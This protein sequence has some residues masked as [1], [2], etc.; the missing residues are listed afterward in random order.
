M[1]LP[2]YSVRFPASAASVKE[3]DWGVASYG[4][5]ALWSQTQG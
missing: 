1:H 3:V 5:P 2:P 4:I